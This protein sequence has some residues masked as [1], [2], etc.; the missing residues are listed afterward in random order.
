MDGGNKKLSSHRMLLASNAS[1][2]Q[3]PGRKVMPAPPDRPGRATL[4]PP[5][6]GIFPSMAGLP[7]LFGWIDPHRERVRSFLRFLAR[8]FI[9]DRCFDSA[10]TLAYA[11]LF[12]AVPL[13]A[14]VFGIVSMFPIYE[15]WV[16][17]LTRFIFAN[18]MPTAA[19]S[20][21]SFLAEAAGNA[22]TLSAVGAI[23]VLL[24]ALLTLSR[25]E[26]TFNRIWRV[27]APRRALS[28]LLI[29]WAAMTLLPLLAVASFAVSSYLT[30]LPL[31]ADEAQHGILLR[32][33]PVGLELLTFTLAY[34][35]I[36]NRTV[37]FRHTLIAGALATLLFELAKWGFA[38]YLTRANYQA[39]YGA[40]A[41]V[42]IFLIWLY[43][44][45]VVVLLGAS[46][47]ASLS[48]F[49]YQPAQQRL[50]AGF[51]LY[52]L[53]RLLGRFSQAQGTGSSLHTA[54][55]Q[56][57]EPSI[58]D[59][60]LMHLLAA[61]SEARVIQRLDDGGYALVRD[62]NH[63]PL[64]EL[65]ESAALRIPLTQAPLPDGGDASGRRAAAELEALRAPL[66][67]R[68]RRSVAQILNGLEE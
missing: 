51:E 13:A 39:L 57:L 47:A 11:T 67:E 25:I 9:E 27:S 38:L 56:Q 23:T 44:S 53:L 14:V 36:P 24:T 29:Y 30:S 61:L 43:V 34:R 50:P 40:I 35:L 32:V 4:Q 52:G 22:R 6:P 28:R 58:S 31:L 54:H 45:W 15:N 49:R 48:A 18:F 20:V 1:T 16:E 64:A 33:L 68:M 3:A 37:V 55:L 7:N 26:D 2:T 10:A 65:Y 63:L 19:D 5:L 41:V 17:D 42:P 46:L 62:L 8:R 12:A 21:A 60:V 59:D 66:R